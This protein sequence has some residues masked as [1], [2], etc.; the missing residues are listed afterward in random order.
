[1]RRPLSLSSVAKAEEP[2]RRRVGRCFCAIPRDSTQANTRRSGRR[3]IGGGGRAE[4]AAG[5]SRP[6][7]G[8]PAN[9]S[10]AYSRR[11]GRRCIG[12]AECGQAELATSGRA[13]PGAS[14]GGRVGTNQK[15]RRTSPIGA[16]LDRRQTFVTSP[17]LL[18]VLVATSAPMA[19]AIGVGHRRLKVYFT[20]I[21]YGCITIP[22]Q[23]PTS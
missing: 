14:L 19:A 9:R 12:G 7:P 1:M 16:P 15:A 5:R 4:A 20:A 21:C 2:K 6:P 11:S 10:Q 18:A 23:F 17:L 13:R 3:C 8:I 22:L